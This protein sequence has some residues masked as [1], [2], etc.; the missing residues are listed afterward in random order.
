MFQK[1]FILLFSIFLLIN[2][3]TAFAADK[4][5]RDECDPAIDR[6]ITPGYSCLKNPIDP[7][8]YNCQLSAPQ[9]GVNDPCD[10]KDPAKSNCISG[11]SC[12]PIPIDPSRH[13]CQ[14]SSAANV[15]GKITPPDALK[16]IVSKDPTGA[17]GLSLILTNIVALIYSLAAVVLVFMFVLGAWEWLTSGGDKE[18]IDSARKK[19]SNAIIGIILFAV[20]FAVIQVLSTFTGFKFFEPRV[21]EPVACGPGFQRNPTS[22]I[23]EPR[24]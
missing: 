2:A 15:F 18:K 11:Y 22:D 10:P 20:A 17:G 14:K 16:G 1:T 9:L 23:C 3:S 8:K 7:S 24:P 5:V 4:G 12:Q 6:C 13:A 21:R 19:I